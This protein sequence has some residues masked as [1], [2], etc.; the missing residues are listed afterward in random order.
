MG[1]LTSAEGLRVVPVRVTHVDAL[2]GGRALLQRVAGVAGELHY[3]PDVIGRV[4]CGEIPVLNVGFVA[5]AL[6][7]G[8]GGDTKREAAPPMSRGLVTALI[9]ED[10]SPLAV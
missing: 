6:L 2:D 3:G 4:G 7:K 10:G 8:W 5:V 1:S 9:S